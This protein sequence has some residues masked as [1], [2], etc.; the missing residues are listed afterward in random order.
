MNRRNTCFLGKLKKISIFF[1]LLEINGSI[2]PGGMA[3]RIDF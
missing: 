2:L 1:L 3:Y